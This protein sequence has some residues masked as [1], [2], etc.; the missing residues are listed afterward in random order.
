M[1]RFPALFVAVLFAVLPRPAHAAPALL[2]PVFGGDGIVTAFPDGAI[3]TA[4]GIDA[5]R[6]I[7]A[8]GYT[9]GRHVDVVIARFL[10]DGTPD[11]SF[12]AKGASTL[13]P[14]RRRLRL[15]RGRDPQ[16]GDRGRR[17]ALQRTGS[18]VRAPRPPR[19]DAP[20]EL[21]APRRRRSSTS[22]SR[23]R[24]RTRS[25]S[26]RQGRIVVGGY[27]TNGVGRPLGARPSVGPRQARP[28]VRRRRAGELRHRVGRGAD[29][30]RPRARRRRDRR[31]RRRRE[32][33]EPAVQRPVASAAT[34][35]SITRSAR[36]TTAARR[37]TS[38]PGPTSRTRSTIAANGDYLLAGYAGAHADSAV[39]RRPAQRPARHELRITRTRRHQAR[40]RV[41]GG[42]GHRSA[43]RQ[44]PAGRE[45]PRDRRRHRRVRLKAGGALDTSFSG[46]GIV[47]I[48]V[49]GST[50]AGAAGLLQPNGKLVVAGQTWRN[51]LPHFLLARLQT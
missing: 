51:G 6:R 40:A 1:R 46:D 5:D 21:R 50:D 25:P 45:D 37:S 43:G 19:R 32:R 15:R 39:R 35:S 20:A 8:V 34:G 16:R 31:G 38:R 7:V 10:P 3:A 42:D 41:R 29:Q 9:T 13:R 36:A 23:S 17:P 4:V 48:D 22:A 27:T 12:G 11:S 33:S 18:D 49:N 44:G 24:A 2:D 30:R 14:R 47:R 26:R 28:R